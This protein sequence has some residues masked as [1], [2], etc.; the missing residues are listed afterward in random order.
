MIKGTRINIA[1]VLK[2]YSTKKKT[3]SNF[4]LFVKKETRTVR[5]SFVKFTLI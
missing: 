2:V 1:V 4:F 3:G 5:V